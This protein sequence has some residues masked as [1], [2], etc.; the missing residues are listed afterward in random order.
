MLYKLKTEYFGILIVFRNILFIKKMSY[1][2]LILEY[3][4]FA[5]RDG[6]FLCQVFQ[7]HLQTNLSFSILSC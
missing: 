4:I 5:I 7:L 3:S 1:F 6:K 2:P